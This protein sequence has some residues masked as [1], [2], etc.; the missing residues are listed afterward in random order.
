VT[1]ETP[2]RM[3]ALLPDDPLAVLARLGDPD[4]AAAMAARERARRQFLGIPA[5]QLHA[6]TDGWRARLDIAGRV[7]LARQLWDSD[8]HE[9]RLAAARLLIQARIRA[10]EALVW[11]EFLRWVPDFDNR[12]LADQACKVGERRLVAEPARLATIENWQDD[13]S[14]WIRRALLVV[15]LPWSKLSHPDRAEAGAR[16]RI[17]AWAGR[18]AADPDP[19]VQRAVADWLQALGKRDPGR[20]RAFLAAHGAMMLPSIRRHIARRLAA[21]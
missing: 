14:P 9:A 2:R 21:G 5:P 17:L 4:R 20:G 11:Q 8:I 12:S 16:E 18:L 1:S 7:A 10:G 6:V 3:T 19:L 15:T 13:P